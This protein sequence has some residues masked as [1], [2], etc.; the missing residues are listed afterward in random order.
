MMTRADFEP[1]V[2]TRFEAVLQ[3]GGAVELQLAEI[4]DRTPDGFPGEQFSLVFEGAREPALP[5][6]LYSMRHES[7]KE[8]QLFLVPIGVMGDK[9]VYEAAFSLLGA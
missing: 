3:D 5:Q 7:F 1:H 4:S 2:R 8:L 6:S 9:R